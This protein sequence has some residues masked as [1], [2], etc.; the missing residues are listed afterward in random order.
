MGISSLWPMALGVAIPL[1][2]LL[3]ML[4]RKYREKEVASSLLWSEV[5][6]N[7][8]ANTPWEKLRN[9]IMLI[10]Q[11]IVILS[12]ILALMNPFFKFGGKSYKNIIIL[13]DNTGSMSGEYDDKGSRLEEAKNVAIDYI[14]SIKSG[15]NAY[16]VSFDGVCNLELSESND[17]G[18]IKNKISNIKQSYSSGDITDALSFVRSLGEGLNG[19]YE[20]LIISDRNVPL[21]EIKGQSVSLNSNGINASIDNISNKLIDGKVKVI[22][23]VSNRG[24]EPYSGDFTLYDGEEI[25]DVK[26]INLK[27]GEKNTLSFDLNK[28]KNTYLKGELSIKDSIEG[29]NKYIN[30][31]NQNSTKKVL[32]VTERN[33]FMEKAFGTLE[34]VE[35][36]K[37]NDISNIREED[38]YDLYIYDNVTPTNI[39]K[40]GSV[41]FINSDSNEVFTTS[42]ND[43]VS[44][45]FGVNENLSRYLKDIKFTVS[46]YKSLEVPYWGKPILSSGDNT[47]AFIGENNGRTIAAIGLDLHDSDIVLKKEFPILIYELSDKLLSSG[48]LYKSNFKSGEKIE[49]KSSNLSEVSKVTNPDKKTIEVK[50][51]SNIDGKYQLGLYK[52]SEKIQNEENSEVF[53]VNYPSETESN[54]MAVENQNSSNIKD[55]G[56]LLKS[57]FNLGPIFIILALIVVA[58]EWILYLKGN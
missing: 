34:N 24:T 35:L 7:T 18:L 6:K 58:V 56:K 4:K 17:K 27:V 51:G 45:V 13:I 26:N 15:T 23:N 11:I 3:Y 49:L 8:Q 28:V 19:E 36:F 42:V 48:M 20:A 37:T 47:V 9:N 1:L 30:I 32:L 43:K 41:L 50:A 40:S 53:A 31:V 44:E 14:S 12:I 46:N 25:L 2:I 55:N 5:Y 52:V 57:G 29:D 38:S 16:I 10:L 22:A 39:P 33:L 54:L 21:G